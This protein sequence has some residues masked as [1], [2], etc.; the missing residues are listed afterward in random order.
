MQ[1]TKPL[2]LS[3]CTSCKG[4]NYFQFLKETLPANLKAAEGYV[5]AEFVVLGYGTTP[6]LNDWIRDTFP[7]EIKS[8]RLKYVYYPDA[9][10]FKMAHAKN[11]AHRMATGDVLCNVDA[12][13]FIGKDFCNAL[14]EQFSKNLNSVVRAGNKEL[15]GRGIGGRVAIGREKFMMIR[16]Y[17]NQRSAWGG[18]DDMLWRVAQKNGMEGVLVSSKSV[19]GDVIQHGH[20]VRMSNMDEQD[21]KKSRQNLTISKFNKPHMRVFE[22]VRRHFDAERLPNPKGN[23][24]CGTV[25]VNFSED[26][27]TIEPL[28]PLQTHYRVSGRND[29][30]LSPDFQ[31]GGL[32]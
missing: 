3:F 19:V 18:D 26:P 15:N 22:L 25:Y 6:E 27:V 2:K 10:H 23:V 5:N 21:V 14:N 12:D 30:H 24:G 32:I 4:E 16:G 13:N 9:E 17:D 29:G 20:D 1:M 7:D 11:M 8:G 28:R 31:R